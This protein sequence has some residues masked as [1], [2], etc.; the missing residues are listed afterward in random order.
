MRHYFFERCAG[1]PKSKDFWPTS[2]PFL[3]KKG[4]GGGS[5]IILSGNEKNISDQREVC[6]IFNN[7]FVNVAKDIGKDSI[8]NILK[9][10]NFGDKIFDFRPVSEKEV[11]KIISKLNVKKI[12]WCG[13]YFSQNF[14]AY[15]PSFSHA[16]SSLINLLRVHSPV[17]LKKPKL[18]LYTKRRIL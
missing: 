17:S 15:A 4:S 13:L 2:K 14:K 16:V 3:S 6:D 8:Q 5:E 12:H 1:G 7:Y 11:G 18:Y 9:N 10:G